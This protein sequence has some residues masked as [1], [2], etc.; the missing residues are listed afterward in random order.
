MARGESNC[1]TTRSDTAAMLSSLSS[2][3]VVMFA[4]SEKVGDAAYGTYDDIVRGK[5][6]RGQQTADEIDRRNFDYKGD[7]IS[8]ETIG[9]KGGQIQNSNSAAYTYGTAMNLDLDSIVKDAGIERRLPGW[10]RNILS[11][12]YDRYVAPPQFPTENRQ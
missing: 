3:S 7:D 8:Y 12:G 4:R 9:G 11:Q 1:A 6:A 2:I 5:W 10:G